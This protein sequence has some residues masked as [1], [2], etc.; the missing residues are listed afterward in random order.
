MLYRSR[1][2]LSHPHVTTDAHRPGPATMTRIITIRCMAVVVVAD[3]IMIIETA[4]TVGMHPAAFQ[5]RTG[6]W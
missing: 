1:F 5:D 2:C 3:T 6:V 4:E